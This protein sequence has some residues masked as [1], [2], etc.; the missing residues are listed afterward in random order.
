MKLAI[1]IN[2]TG[3]DAGEEIAAALANISESVEE[4]LQTWA[5]HTTGINDSDGRRIGHWS[6]ES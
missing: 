2:I 1:I 6:V 3:E 5:G 4:N